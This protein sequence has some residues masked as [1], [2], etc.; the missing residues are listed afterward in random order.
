MPT[1]PQIPP[2][3]IKELATAAI[4]KRKEE[5]RRAT[6][7]GRRTR[8]VPKISERQ[9]LELTKSLS[10]YYGFAAVPRTNKEHR[11][12][13]NIVAESWVPLTEYERQVL[14]KDEALER[15]EE[16]RRENAQLRARIEQRIK[17]VPRLRAVIRS[18]LARLI[19]DTG[20]KHVKEEWALVLLRRIE[21]ARELLRSELGSGTDE[22]PATSAAD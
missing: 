5:T 2:E 10:D 12:V 18:A 21:A 22:H 14:Y 6:A 3:L 1:E 11:E 8:I 19:V 13:A 17:D 15:I 4:V 20:E 7:G 16:L 9:M